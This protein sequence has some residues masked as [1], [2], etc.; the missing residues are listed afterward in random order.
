MNEIEEIRERLEK[1]IGIVESVKGISPVVK[2]MVV[3]SIN[4]IDNV[5][6]EEDYIEY[7]K[8]MSKNISGM[9]KICDRS[10]IEYNIL[11]HMKLLFERK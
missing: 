8:R 2:S 10:R 4:D 9:L 6:C 7:K 11:E 5:E 3:C 1:A